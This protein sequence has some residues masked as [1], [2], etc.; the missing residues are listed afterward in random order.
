MMGKGNSLEVTIGNNSGFSPIFKKTIYAV[1]NS[2]RDLAHV[3]GI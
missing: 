3:Y 1:G 2:I